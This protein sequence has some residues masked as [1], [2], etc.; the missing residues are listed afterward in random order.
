MITMISRVLL[1]SEREDVI[2]NAAVDNN[3]TLRKKHFTMHWKKSLNC[4]ERRSQKIEHWKTLSLEPK[5]YAKN[6]SAEELN[7][8]PAT[9]LLHWTCGW[10]V[11]NRFIA[12]YHDSGG[13]FPNLR[14][15]CLNAVY[16]DLGD[17]ESVSSELCSD[18]VA[19]DATADTLMPISK[20]SSFSSSTKNFDLTR[21]AS[22][23]ALSDST[24]RTANA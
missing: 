22:A 19:V 11:K 21:S 5:L 2:N 1:S 18:G 3:T 10:Q 7:R 23:F 20:S 13:P 14:L 6:D 16:N 12:C 9:L 15:S 17:D 8:R 24:G 4:V